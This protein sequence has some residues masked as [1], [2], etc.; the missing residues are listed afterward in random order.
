MD[1]WLPEPLERSVSRLRGNVHAA[2]DRWVHRHEPSSVERSRKLPVR[3]SETVDRLHTNIHEAVS[4]WL[5]RRRASGNGKEQLR[6]PSAF[7]D[8]GP[9]ISLEETADEVVVVAEMPGFDE[10]DFSVEVMNDRLILR[11]SKKQ[12]TEERGRNFYYAERSFGGFTRVLPLPCEV[13]V[14][15]AIARYK[16]GLLRVILPKAEHAQAKRIE[17]RST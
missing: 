6:S 3:S 11:G 16:N 1:R 10:K 2:L 15:R 7:D 17:I 5:P 12:E 13:D 14:T 4:R 9:P 8:V